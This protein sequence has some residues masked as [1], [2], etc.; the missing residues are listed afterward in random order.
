MFIAEVCRRDRRGHGVLLG[1]AAK[2]ARNP[3]GI[4]AA[5]IFCAER[6]SSQ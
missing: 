3:V 6:L 2:K 4:V 5:D 1:I